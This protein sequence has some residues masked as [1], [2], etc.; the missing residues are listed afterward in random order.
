VWQALPGNKVPTN[1]G[2]EKDRLN[3][4]YLYYNAVTGELDKAYSVLV[5]S[6][7]LFPRD[8]F[9]HTNLAHTLLKLGQPKR[10]ADLEDETARLEPSTLYFSWAASDNI[11]ASR[12]KE[13]RSWLAQAEA[14]K[15]VSLELRIQRLRVAFV[16]RDRATLDWIFEGEAHGPNR[17]V[18]LREESKFEAQQGYFDS[19]DRLQQQAIRHLGLRLRFTSQQQADL[20]RLR[21][22]N[23]GAFDAY[24]QLAYLERPGVSTLIRQSPEMQLA[25]LREYAFLLNGGNTDLVKLLP[26]NLI[27]S[28]QR[29]HSSNSKSV[30]GTGWPNPSNFVHNCRRSVSLTLLACWQ[31]TPPWE[32]PSSRSPGRTRDDPR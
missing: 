25:E 16:E 15:F 10:A 27:L 1:C 31:S 29:R 12:F 19:A 20:A 30:N 24:M 23:P 26:S 6:L 28:A 18:F 5:R 3:A 21:P 8:V 17:V 32:S 4:E 14:L 2:T 13:A 7:E 9:L 22:P 11:V